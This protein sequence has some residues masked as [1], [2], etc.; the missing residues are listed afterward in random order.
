MKQGLVSGFSTSN[1]MPRGFNF[2]IKSTNVI[3]RLHFIIYCIIYLDN[4]FF[5]VYD[6]IEPLDEEL[7]GHN[8]KLYEY[9]TKP[10]EL[11]VVLYHGSLL[12]THSS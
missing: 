11:Y 6:T 10:R 4:A 12:I 2:V 8:I 9:T 5:A 3:V 7:L 1:H